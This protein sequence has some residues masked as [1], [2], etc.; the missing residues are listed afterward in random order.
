MSDFGGAHAAFRVMITRAVR[1]EVLLLR[2]LPPNICRPS[3]VVVDR[4]ICA[5]VFQI[6]G[7]SKDVQTLDQLKCS[8]RQLPLPAKF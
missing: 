4:A 6:L 7:V 1:R 5:A 8:M 2:T 3:L